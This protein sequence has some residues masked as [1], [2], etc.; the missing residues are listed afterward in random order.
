MPTTPVAWLSESAEWW[1]DESNEDSP[2]AGVQT[3]DLSNRKLTDTS[4]HLLPPAL[5]C[6]DLSRC[7]LET[8]SELKRLP[9]LE[10]LNLSYNRLCSVEDLRCSGGLKVLYARSNRIRSLEGLA[11]LSQ[12]QSLDLEC[13]ALPSLDALAPLW[14]LS[15]LAELRL[16]GNLVP[17]AAYRRASEVGPP[18]PHPWALA[19]HNTHHPRGPL[20]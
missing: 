17:A 20:P 9:R 3:L 4:L 10:L 1:G 5:T 15:K 16:R 19:C 14:G 6:L 7:G 12:L 8:A 2:S 11:G 13:N 18:F